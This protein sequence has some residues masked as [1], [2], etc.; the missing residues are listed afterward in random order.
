MSLPT[1]DFD[2]GLRITRARYVVLSVCDLT[3]SRQFYEEVIGLILT[4]EE[5]DAFNFRGVEEACHHSL[6]LQGAGTPPARG[7]AY[8]CS[9]TPKAFFEA[10]GC[11]ANW[12]EVPPHRATRARHRRVRHAARILCQHAGD[13]TH[14]HQ[15]HTRH[16]DGSCAAPPEVGKAATST[17]RRASA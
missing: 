4:A 3:A 11:P 7:W 6:V 5:D 2:P 15:V 12:V 17:R 8:A 9:W 16:A 14:D 1:T 10:H 13:A